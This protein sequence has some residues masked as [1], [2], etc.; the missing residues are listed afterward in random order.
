MAPMVFKG[1]F[2]CFSNAGYFF[3]PTAGKK[4]SSD[5]NQ[6]FLVRRL[7]HPLVFLRRRL[8]KT[9]VFSKVV[10]Y[11]CWKIRFFYSDFSTAPGRTTAVF[12]EAVNR[13][14]LKGG[15]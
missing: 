14:I 10:F 4:G 7:E 6:C 13:W 8:E 5:K 1:G 9:C 2:L 11:R 3:R 15:G 12:S